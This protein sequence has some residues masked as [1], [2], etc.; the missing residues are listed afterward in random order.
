MRSRSW[1]MT[2]RG[3]LESLRAHA[4]CCLSKVTL[5]GQTAALNHGLRAARAPLIAR[6]DAADVPLPER[7][8]RQAPFQASHPDVGLLGSGRARD[9]TVRN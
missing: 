4:V 6:I 3:L 8:A 5:G 9:R 1:R 7:L 2:R